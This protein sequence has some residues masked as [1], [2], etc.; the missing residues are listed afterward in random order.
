MIRVLALAVAV[1]SS[2][3]LAIAVSAQT[4][5]QMMTIRPAEA[6]AEAAKAGPEGGRHDQVGARRHGDARGRDRALDPELGQGRERPAETRRADQR[7][8]RKEGGPEGRHVSANQGIGLRPDPGGHDEQASI[9]TVCAR[10]THRAR[11][12]MLRYGSCRREA[13][14]RS[15]AVGL[16]ADFAGHRKHERRPAERRGSGQRGSEEHAVDAEPVGHPSEPRGDPRRREAPHPPRC[17]PVAAISRSAEVCHNSARRRDRGSPQLRP[18]PTATLSRRRLRWSDCAEPPPRRASLCIVAVLAGGSDGRV[19]VPLWLGHLSLAAPTDAR[20]LRTTDEAVRGI[21]TIMAKSFGLPVPERVI[22]PRLRRT[23][24]LRAGIDP[25]RSRLPDPGRAAERLRDR[26]GRARPGAPERSAG[27]AHRAR[28]A[29]LD[30]PRAHPRVA[31][32]ARRRRRAWRAVARRGHGGV[33]GVLDARAP[34]PRHRGTPSAG[35]DGRPSQPRPAIA[36]GTRSR[37]P[38]ERRRASPRGICARARSRSISSR[39][40]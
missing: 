27:G 29:A 3:A 7:G 36:A 15:G 13:D 8:V 39:F 30:R 21:A 25:G 34:G 38:T 23:P 20:A 28:M 33:G 6:G 10:A 1:L 19:A 14:P 22:G 24:G 17:R 31:D 5:A 32:R 2:A 18:T 12:G 40:S 35:G 11:R 4:S 16:A 9:W 26:G 37:R